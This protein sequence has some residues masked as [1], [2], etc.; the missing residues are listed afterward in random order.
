MG[1][2]LYAALKSGLRFPSSSAQRGVQNLELDSCE[3]VQVAQNWQ[4]DDLIHCRLRAAGVRQARLRKLGADARVQAFSP[5]SEV[6]GDSI[7]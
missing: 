6:S 2:G 3:F 7:L 5:I 1:T 4:T